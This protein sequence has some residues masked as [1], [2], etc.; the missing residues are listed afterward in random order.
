[1]LTNCPM[2]ITYCYNYWQM[3]K[4][5]SE[6]AAHKK[7]LRSKVVIPKKKSLK[8]ITFSY[9]EQFS[10]GYSVSLFHKSSCGHLLLKG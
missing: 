5:P 4:N 10:S 9:R 6:I 1:M 7:K 8:V 3:Y 2:K